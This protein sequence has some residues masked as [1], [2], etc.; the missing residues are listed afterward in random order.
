M[1]ILN[2]LRSGESEIVEFKASFGKEVIITLSARAN[3]KGG[4]VVAGVDN[5]GRPTGIDIG[6]ETERRYLNEIK[7]ATY[8]QIIPGITPVEIKGK[9]VLV[10]EIS[11]YPVKP[12]SYKNRYYK[13][14]GNSNHVLSLDEIV[15][16]QQQSLNLSFDAFPLKEDLSSLDPNM[17]DRFFEKVNDT[18]R[19]S[20]RDDPLANLSKL[21]IIQNGKPTLA[22]MLLFGNHG[23]S[24]HMGRFKSPDTIIDDLMLKDPL[25][26]AIE[27]G[28]DFYQKAY[29]PFL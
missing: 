20:L 27:E 8:P 5:N 17:M 9:N 10:F 28:H 24:I 25:P 23:Y 19:A 18:G 13:R 3:T 11:E 2:I 6:P 1:D 22:A 4:K 14:V 7:V 29:Q 26:V 15:D 16:L 12:V 21:K